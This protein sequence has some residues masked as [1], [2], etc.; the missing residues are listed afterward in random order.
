MTTE[1][2]H[3]LKEYLSTYNQGRPFKAR[4][5]FCHAP[6]ASL[7][8][9][10]NGNITAC[11]FNR[12]HVIGRF[13]ESNIQEL[14]NSQKVQELRQAIREVDLSKGCQLCEKQ[15]LS[16][17]YNSMLTKNFDLLEKNGEE[18]A[19]LGPRIMEFEISNICN[20]ECI[21]CNGYFSS[22]IRKNREYLPPLENPYTDKLIEQIRPFFK[23]LEWIKFLGGEPFMNPLYYKIWRTL[24]E[25]NSP[26]KVVITSNGTVMNSNVRWVLENLK[27]MMVLSIDSLKKVNYER[28]RKNAR[29]E[30]TMMNL[31]IFMQYASKNQKTIDLAVCPMTMNWQEIPEIFDWGTKNSVQ[32]NLNT[33]LS[34]NE[35]SIRNLGKSEIEKIIYYYEN[36]RLKTWESFFESPS[37]WT[38][39]ISDNNNNI[40]NAYVR[41]IRFWHKQ[42]SGS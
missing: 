26:A 24:A 3:P 8:F 23:N 13:P 12:S 39:I 38:K 17:N 15:L 32:V 28:I 9:E 22:S 35:L 36:I 21:M 37:P 33:V 41:Q 1:A 31:G 30:S 16:Q 18:A 34:P 4:S 2:D 40:F 29:F 7:N 14:W 19:F 25:E 11:C 5:H 27:P 6:F 42:L 10:Q 20:L